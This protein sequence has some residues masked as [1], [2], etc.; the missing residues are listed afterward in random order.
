MSSYCAPDDESTSGTRSSAVGGESVAELG[1]AGAAT[2][3]D[4]VGAPTT[5]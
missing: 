4:R 3:T 2:I 1:P 5:P